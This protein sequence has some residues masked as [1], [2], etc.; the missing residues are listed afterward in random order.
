MSSAAKR[1]SAALM[2]CQLKH[3]IRQVRVHPQHSHIPS[4]LFTW[5]QYCHG[6]RNPL[7]QGA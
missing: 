7:L 2:L 4:N 5:R 3:A 6:P 1:S